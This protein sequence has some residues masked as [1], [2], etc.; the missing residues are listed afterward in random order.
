MRCTSPPCWTGCG[1]TFAA[2]SGWNVQYFGSVEPQRRLA[3]HAHFA[4]RGSIPR[5]VIRQVIDATYHQVWWPATDVIAYDVDDPQ[6]VWDPDTGI[7]RDPATRHRRC[8]DWDEALDALDAQLDEDPETAPAHV[9]R[10]GVQANLQGVLAGTPQADQL[11]GYLAKYLTKSVAECHTATT[12][13][14]V[15]HQR[16]LWEELRFTPCSPRCAN[17]LRHGIQPQGARRGMRAGLLPRQSPPTRHVG[18][19]RPPGAGVAA[20]VRQDL[21]RSPPR[22]SPVAAPPPH[23]CPRR[24]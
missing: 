21:G 20:M 22:P 7:Y 5:A 23:P 8:P 9:V 17:W 15:D 18:H 16:R 2:R 10:F 4:I 1:R 3:P 19:R 11:V 24:R 13:A 6:P 12:D 14:A